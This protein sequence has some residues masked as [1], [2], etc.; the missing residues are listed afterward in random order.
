MSWGK[1]EE[2]KLETTLNREKVGASFLEEVEKWSGEKLS[3]CYQCLKCTAG[4]PTAPNMDI[5]PNSIIRM[6]QMGKKQEVLESSA[7]WFCVYCQTCGTRCPNE[8]HIGVLMD[9]LREMAMEE[10][11][12]AKE[13]NIHLFHEAFIQSVRRGGRAHEVTMLMDY[14][15]RSR[16]LMKGSLIP[17][18]KLF[19]KG[20]FPL[21][22]SFVK[23]RGEIK[24]I[25]E[26]CKK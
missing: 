4:C 10:G 17:G 11:V 5:R 13:K 1:M 9:A 7:I 23:G 22:P 18:V 12:H 25:F 8:I 21:I 19:L 15:L 6:I 24:R 20:K 2:I 16:D 14:V 3:L 26:K